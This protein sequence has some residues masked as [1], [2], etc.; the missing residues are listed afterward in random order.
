M[1]TPIIAPPK[2]E[3]QETV[4]LSPL[5]E[6]KDVTKHLTI[7]IPVDPNQPIV[8][9]ITIPVV[10]VAPVIVNDPKHKNLIVNIVEKMTEEMKTLQLDHSTV[11]T[12]LIKIV[13]LIDDENINPDKKKKIILEIIDELIC[14][15]PLDPLSKKLLEELVILLYPA[16]N[17]V[18]DHL[19]S[20]ALVLLKKVQVLVDEEIEP[21]IENCWKKYCAGHVANHCIIS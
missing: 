2:L 17:I 9:I 5:T 21:E 4:L 6:V 13:Q 18:F 14:L 10:S 1:T 15:T 11:L 7:E 8:P 12:Y 16:I 3:R 20:G 19:E